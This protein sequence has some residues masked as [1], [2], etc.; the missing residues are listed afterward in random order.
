MKKLIS[1]AL[2]LMLVFSLATV[3]MAADSEPDYDEVLGSDDYEDM[4]DIQPKINKTYTIN[5]D[6][7][8]APEETFTLEF[9]GISYVNGAGVA[10]T[11]VTIPGISD[12]TFEYGTDFTNSVASKTLTIDPDDY[13]IG[14]YTYKITEENNGT[15]GVTYTDDELYL[16]LTILY[17][18]TEA[19]H[20]VAAM[21][22]ASA[23]GSKVNSIENTYSAGSLV[24]SKEISGNAADMTAEFEFVVTFTAPQGTE[25]DLAVSN[26][27]QIVTTDTP[28]SGY[29]TTSVTYKFDLGNGDSLSFENIPVGTMYTVTETKA[30]EDN[31]TTTFTGTIDTNGGQATISD[32]SEA[33]VDVVN[34]RSSDVDTGITLD[35]LPFVLILA[36]CAGAVVLFVVKRRRSVD[37]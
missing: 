34:A 37:F 35:S 16:V 11:T 26:G 1:L 28:E 5:G 32:T 21:H 8:V 9:E 14:V 2:A 18:E 23:G 27:V 17:N 33:T 15:A 3:A 4:I 7:A 30:N 20:F 10:D 25:F 24:V 29:S 36:V 19:K 12:V 22:V 13:E 6:T 31:Y